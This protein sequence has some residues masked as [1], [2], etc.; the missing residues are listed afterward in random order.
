MSPHL[1]L[2]GSSKVTKNLAADTDDLA[3]IN[4]CSSTGMDFF[5]CLSGDQIRCVSNMLEEHT[6]NPYQNSFS[7]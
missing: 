6:Q 3:S 2:T 5:G 1:D 4:G 7:K